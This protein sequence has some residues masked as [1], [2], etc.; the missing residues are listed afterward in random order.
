MANVRIA[1]KHNPPITTQPNP[2]YSSDPA[3]GK[4]TSGTIPK[5]LVKV[6]IKMGLILFLVD[7]IIASLIL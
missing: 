1:D 5:I 4:T 2:L 6:D 7:S 3:P